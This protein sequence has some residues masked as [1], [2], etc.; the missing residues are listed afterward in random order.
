MRSI[1]TLAALCLAIFLAGCNST[2]STSASTSPGAM[3]ECGPNCTM[4]CCAQGAACPADCS[5]PCCAAAACCGEGGSCCAAGKPACGPNCTK[6]CCAGDA[7]MGAVS[8]A[9]VACPANCAKP[10]DAGK[11]NMSAVSDAPASCAPASCGDK[12]AAP[13]CPSKRNIPPA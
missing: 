1:I 10:C 8:D 13:C 6:P 7:Q 5:K 2:Q 11:T 9:P 3:S 12:A 4:K